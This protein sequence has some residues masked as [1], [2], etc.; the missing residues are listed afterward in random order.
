MKISLYIAKRYLFSSSSSNAI[1][2]I[3]AIAATGVVVGSLVLFIVL[4]GF[5]GLKAY[6]L[7]YTNI[8]DSDLKVYPAS[9]KTIRFTQGQ[10][11]ALTS[12]PEVI[13]ASQTIEERVFIQFK[14]K[15]DMAF[16]KGVDAHYDL[17]NPTDS[18]L[19]SREWLAPNKREV[20][21]GY[22]TSHKKMNRRG[23]DLE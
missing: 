14:G 11:K 1:N 2:I 9:G 16:I 7:E 12:L 17:V 5:S 20:V 15:N 18:I 21:I 6:S 13:A 3:T 22:N 19:L 10:K 4:S 23:S 8:F